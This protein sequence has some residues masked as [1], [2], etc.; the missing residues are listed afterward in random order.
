MITELE[1]YSLWLDTLT[2]M[3]Y[4]DYV[5][6]LRVGEKSKLEAYHSKFRFFARNHIKE[7]VKNN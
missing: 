6:A 5:A 1:L 3:Q 7:L 4:Q 2:P